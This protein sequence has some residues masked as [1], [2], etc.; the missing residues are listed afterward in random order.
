MKKFGVNVDRKDYSSFNIQ[1]TQIYKAGNYYVEPDCSQAGYFW[2]AAAITGAKIKVK[3]ISK[4]SSQGDV[5]FTDVLEKMGCKIY[6]EDDGIAV[7]GQELSAIEVDM[8]NMPDIVPT[9]S[10]VAAF[11][12]GTTIIKNVAH[13]REKE[14]DRLSSVATELSK[15]GIEAIVTDDGLIIKGG[16][17]NGAEIDTYNDHRIAMCFAVSGLVVPGIIIKDEKCVEKSF[18]EFWN[19]F[20]RLYE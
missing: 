12:K 13:L 2:A 10:V 17:P 7:E 16:R 3:G 9:L 1:G 4:K 14:S 20:E 6:H 8:A 18:P 5:R 15:M 11:A 19:V